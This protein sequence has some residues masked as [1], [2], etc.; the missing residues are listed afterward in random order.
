[1]GKVHSVQCV[2]WD[3]AQ[4]H[5]LRKGGS[6]EQKEITIGGSEISIVMGLNRWKTPLRLW[7]EKTGRIETEK[8]EAEYLEMGN[9]LED[10]VARIFCKRY[11]KDT[12]RDI[13]VRRD[14]K[15]FRHK[16]F[17]FMT[18]HI[19]RRITGTDLLLE[20]KTANAWKA[21]EWEGEEIPQEYILQVI[22]YLGVTGMKKGYIAVLIGGNRFMWKEI[23]ANPILFMNM[24]ERTKQFIGFCK[25]GIAPVAMSGDS[26]TLMRL[27]PES[28]EQILQKDG[29]EDNAVIEQIQEVKK[30]INEAEVKKEGLEAR[31]KQA[32]GEY[33]GM[34]TGDYKVSWK[35]Q[36]RVQL[37]YARL[38]EDGLY[39]KYGVERFSRVLRINKKKGKK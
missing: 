34:E 23:E 7:A 29:Y 27:Y 15:K 2:G 22:H 32:I 1:M 12:G 38:K 18:G 33:E 35:S 4:D 11:K 9:E 19:D 36:R 28:M 26:S 31:L 5:K 8:R 13:R 3:M 24:V 10:T 39:D 17:P 37:D 21:H 30:I 14:T 16:D 6:M 20:C 25:D